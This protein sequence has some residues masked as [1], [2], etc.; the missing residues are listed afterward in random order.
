MVDEK[1]KWVIPKTEFDQI[2]LACPIC[3]GENLHILEV[4]VFRG[5]DC[6]KITNQKVSVEE[7]VNPNRGVIIDIEYEGECGHCGVLTFH[8]YKGTTYAMNKKL[9]DIC[10]AA[11]PGEERIL[12][13]K[14]KGDI[15]RD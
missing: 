15:F 10:G 13:Y 4:D 2:A 14:E 8:F 7:A 6:I 11:F 3:K 9:P 1:N 12:H 5:T